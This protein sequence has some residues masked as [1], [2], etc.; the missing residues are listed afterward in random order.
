VS[1]YQKFTTQTGK[2]PEVVINAWQA[3]WQIPPSDFG[4]NRKYIADF[5]VYNKRA[6]DPNDTMV[7]IFIGIE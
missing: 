3:I 1:R 6:S 5:E 4:G 2:M 7:D